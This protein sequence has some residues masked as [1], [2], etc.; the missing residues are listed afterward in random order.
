M[1]SNAPAGTVLTNALNSSETY[2]VGDDGKVTVNLPKY[3]GV[4][5]VA[6]YTAV[7]VNTADLKDVYDE[8]Y[9]VP[10]K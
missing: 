5:L 9:I 10:A 3:S 6:K 8:A 4:I 1:D 7:I 2:T